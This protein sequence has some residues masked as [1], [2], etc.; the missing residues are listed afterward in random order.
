MAITTEDIMDGPYTG[1]GAVDQE[2]A[3][4]FQSDSATGIAVYLEGVLINPVSYTFNREDD[5][6]GTVIATLDGEVTIYSDPSF[7]RSG[8]FQRFGPY[9]PDNLNPHLDKGVIR[10]LWLRGETER[11]AK[12][13][14]GSA[15]PLLPTPAEMAGKFLVGNASGSALLPTSGTGADGALRTDLADTTGAS[16]ISLANGDTLQ[17]FADG[18]GSMPLQ[19]GLFSEIITT[20][21]PADQ[22]Y[23]WT[24]GH[25]IEKIGPAIYKRD[26][27]VNAAAVLAHPNLLAL[28]ADGNGWRIAERHLIPQ[29]AGA[30]PA[31]AADVNVVCTDNTAAIQALLNYVDTISPWQDTLVID[32]SSGAWGL[33]DTLVIPGD[34]YRSHT[35]VGGLFKYVGAGNVDLMIDFDAAHFQDIRGVWNLQGNNGGTGLA[36]YAARKVRDFMRFRHANSA[37]F[38]EFYGQNC[39]RFLMTEHLT[40]DPATNNNIGL[41]IGQLFGVGCGVFGRGGYNVSSTYTSVSHEGSG[42]GVDTDQ[43]S[44]IELTNA[45]MYDDLE[46]GDALVQLGE[47]YH[48]VDIPDDAPSV[49][50]Q[51]I[52]VHPWLTHPSDP[53]TNLASG[54]LWGAW[55][56][57]LNIRNND[58]QG[59]YVEKL[60]GNFV[61][62][63]LKHAGQYGIHIGNLLGENISSSVQIGLG[64]GNICRGVV[65]DT[66]HTEGA[67]SAVEDVGGT[68]YQVGFEFV[69]FTL[70]RCEIIVKHVSAIGLDNDSSVLAGCR[71]VGPQSGNAVRGNVIDSPY[72]FQLNFGGAVYRSNALSP[73]SYGPAVVTTREVSNAPDKR[74]HVITSNSYAL[75]TFYDRAADR[76]LGECHW[77]EA[78]VVGTANAPGAPSGSVTV[79][80]GSSDTTN[81]YTINGG[82][83]PVTFAATAARA[84]HIFGYFNYETEDWVVK[85]LAA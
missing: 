85:N 76:F 21:F 23:I 68:I 73:R 27:T 62:S 64:S 63:V 74:Q 45:A 32:F 26:P 69:I 42:G 10:D 59:L 75:T 61:G 36:S 44:V 2:F 11:S 54:T 80:L 57:V 43:Y 79:A 84:L 16:L 60:T 39:R 70:L 4:T 56:G 19:F 82:A 41:R 48:V 28:D 52:H 49:A 7:L 6:T 67:T 29:M 20:S 22:L 37:K 78:K 72:G 71:L 51:V 65:I 14:L 12:V 24:T 31:T 1:T 13:P 50:D 58:A 47:I 17:Q 15:G 34:Y 77:W 81:G 3:V 8:D 38:A 30:N 25:F 33:S 66:Y 18:I 83:G 46:I 40:G 53:T 35:Y 9:F 55:G 5:G